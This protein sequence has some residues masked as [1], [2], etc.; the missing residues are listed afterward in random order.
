MAWGQPPHSDGDTGAVLRTPPSL[1]PHASKEATLAECGGHGASPGDVHK[2]ACEPGRNPRRNLRETPLR[3]EPELPEGKRREI[4]LTGESAR[5]GTEGKALC[6]HPAFAPRAA[7]AGA[8]KNSG[9][10]IKKRFGAISK[11]MKIK[12]K[13]FMMNKI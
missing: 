10:A 11:Q 12:A 5:Q 1:T 7:P 6:C 9:V 2:G 3:A 13:N 8:A 4:P